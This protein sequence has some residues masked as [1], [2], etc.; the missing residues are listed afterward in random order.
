MKVA[1]LWFFQ[2]LYL[3]LHTLVVMELTSIHFCQCFVTINFLNTTIT[4]I[5]LHLITQ[6]SKVYI[7]PRSFQLYN[8]NHWLVEKISLRV[9]HFSRTG[10]A[11]NLVEL[12]KIKWNKI[13]GKSDDVNEYLFVWINWS[14]PKVASDHPPIALWKK[15]RQKSNFPGST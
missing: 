13:D 1:S 7:L 8:S 14:E 2:P 12:H 15:I 5:Y 3:S 9:M 11:C 10:K 6:R 4:I